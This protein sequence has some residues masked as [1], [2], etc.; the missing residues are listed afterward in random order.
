MA[1]SEI[2]ICNMALSKLGEEQRINSFN[3]NTKAAQKCAIFY[4]PARQALLAEFLW[5]FAR[6]REVLAPLVDAPSFDGGNYFQKPTSCLRIVGTD[7][8]YRYGYGRWLSEG[9]KIIADT[10]ALKLVY[11]ADITDVTLFDAAFV[12]ALAC[13]LAIDLSIPMTQSNTRRSEMIDEFRA[14]RTSSAFISA[15]EIDSEK[16]IAESFIGAHR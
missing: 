14:Y 13:K 10:T 3:D 9:N 12:Q 16:F 7:E 2:Q 11:I 15:T 8:D 1:I 5:R 4:E 6:K